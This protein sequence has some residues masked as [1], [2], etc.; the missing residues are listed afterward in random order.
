MMKY[1]KMVKKTIYTVVF[2]AVLV[3][4]TASTTYLRKQQTTSETLFHEYASSQH[5][6]LVHSTHN[7]IV[8]SANRL[9]PL[10]NK[11]KRIKQGSYEVV[12]IV[13]IGDSHVQAGYIDEPIRQYFKR[14]F[15]DAGA[16]LIVP[17]KL[18]K[19]NQP[20]HF[21]ITSPNK[22]NGLTVIND[23]KEDEVGLTG[24]RISSNDKHITFNI[25]SEYPFNTIRAF[26]HPLAPPLRLPNS[27]TGL[28]YDL[29]DSLPSLSTIYLNN[30]VTQISLTASIT[31]NQFHHTYYGFSLETRDPGVLIH[32]IGINSAAFAHYNNNPQ[33]INQ[34][35]ALSPDLIVVALGT[36]DSFG[37][38][39]VASSVQSQIARF[40]DIC[41]ATLPNTPLLFVTP[42]EGCSSK[43][44][45][46]KRTYSVNRNIATT[47]EMI[48]QTA[49]NYSMP[50]WDL[51]NAA[52]G[53]GSN[54]C[55]TDQGLMGK[56]RL[57]LTIEGYTLQ[58]DMWYEAFTEVYNMR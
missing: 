8:D 55:W 31:E 6:T 14:D 12:S 46:R 43:I 32:A 17:L 57:H 23:R 4:L 7:T 28:F 27:I 35:T 25:T 1:S 51:Y 22:W 53:M 49:R 41:I 15:G 37:N 29:P 30:S 58:A 33:I 24:M 19:T 16:G 54:K 44:V 52:G 34:L 39:Y 50:Y 42:M 48:I 5:A 20:L 10:I 26:H 2:V 13:H 36:N 38:N 18:I 45:K 3:S 40:T 9:T 21:S 56:D 11:L 47:G